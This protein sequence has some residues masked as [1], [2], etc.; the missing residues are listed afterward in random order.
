MSNLFLTTNL[1]DRRKEFRKACESFP[2][3]QGSWGMLAR[4][5]EVQGKSKE[6][7]DVRAQMSALLNE[8]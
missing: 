2:H 6:A 3:I 4:I 8:L 5:L 7:A 1:C